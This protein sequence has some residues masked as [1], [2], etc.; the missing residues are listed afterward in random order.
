[1]SERAS[2]REDAGPTDRTPL[3]LAALLLVAGGAWALAPGAWPDKL[4]LL[5]AGVCRQRPDHS[6]FL[7]G[8]QLPLEARMGGI[9]AGFLV[10]VLWL[11]WAGRERAGLLP[12]RRLQGVLAGCVALLALDGTNALVYDLAGPALYPPQNWLR[13]VTGLLGGLALAL[14]ALP[15]WAS[16]LWRTWDAEPSVAQLRELLAP[17]TWL[18]LVVAATL[19][20]SAGLY[21]PLAGLLLLG[22]LVAFTVGNSYAL[23]LLLGRQGR[24]RAWSDLLTPL[25]G[26]F[27]L[28]GA[29]LALLAALRHWLAALGVEWPV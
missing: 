26:G 22:V 13:L 2:T 27:V 21:Y 17:L 20:G 3:A 5:A 24:A 4:A 29:E 11:W 1:M 9:F 10:G 14:L 28:S 8:T 12:P 18:A 23:A 6:Y 19:S 15:V 16:T 25:L 7:G